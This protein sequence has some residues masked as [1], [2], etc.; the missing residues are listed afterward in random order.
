VSNAGAV[1]TSPS[2]SPWE[3]RVRKRTAVV[4]RSPVT[5][6]ALAVA[7]GR[8]ALSRCSVCASYG[9]A[10]Y[11]MIDGVFLPPTQTRPLVLLRLPNSRKITSLGG[12]GGLPGA[13]RYPAIFL[14]HRMFRAPPR[15][16]RTFSRASFLRKRPSQALLLTAS[17]SLMASSPSSRKVWCARRISL[18]A[19]DRAARFVPIR[20]LV[21][22]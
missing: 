5:I 18:R 3:D 7:G 13:G 21:C 1:C 16:A 12:S 22:R 9:C 19:M 20:S 11:V 15:S 10:G 4:E 17:G 8:P 14:P 6:R 2:R